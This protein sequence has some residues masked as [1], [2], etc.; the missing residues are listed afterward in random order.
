[1][2]KLLI[3]IL[4]IFII[5]ILYF[6]YGNII[7]S[8]NNINFNYTDLYYNN[9]ILSIDSCK[10]YINFKESL[11]PYLR[12]SSRKE[13]IFIKENT[14][15]PKVFYII[16]GFNGDKEECIDI[17]KLLIKTYPYNCYFA[18]MPDHG[19]YNKESAKSTYYDY[20]RSVYDDLIIC[21]LLG[22]EIIIISSS[23]GSTYSILASV[24]FTKTFNI[25]DNIMFSPNIEPYGWVS[26]GTKI[27]ASGYGNFIINLTQ[28]RIYIDNYII[29]SNIF[30]PI[31][32]SLK[33]LRQIKDK[34][35]NNFIIFTSEHDDIIS[36]VAI[37]DFFKRAKSHKK[38]LYTL[39]NTRKHPISR[40]KQAFNVFNDKISK[41]F[42]TNNTI[43]NE[44]ISFE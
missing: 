3:F 21:S 23:T 29:S 18:R 30:K 33:S 35:T 20:L 32:S 13:I 38:Y 22:D 14:K 5:L 41:Y 19:I 9:K 1:M 15:T 6:F 12:F 2:Y 34:F 25:K 24:Y 28:N 11:E 42:S 40:L 39:K 10:D 17:V 27:L 44:L 37:Q 43:I 16:H 8:G 31:V 4:V 26:L 36:N 7:E